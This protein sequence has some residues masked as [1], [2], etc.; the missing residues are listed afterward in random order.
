M[1]KGVYFPDYVFRALNLNESIIFLI[2]TTPLATELLF[3]G[4]AH[5]ILVRGTT[6]QNY[7]NRWFFS[8][9]VII[10]AIL[11]ASFITGLLILPEVSKGT[12]HAQSTAETAFAA[13]AFGLVNGVVRERSHSIFPAIVFHIIAVMAIAMFLT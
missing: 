13:F 8:Y 10:S 1:A 9:P 5:G 2:I 11:Y 3:R 12:F 7:N 6:V 4:L